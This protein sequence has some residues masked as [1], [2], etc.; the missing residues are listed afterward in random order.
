[1]TSGPRS[2]P[3]SAAT[4]SARSRAVTATRGRR[5]T[6]SAPTSETT[7][8]QRI[9]SC[10]NAVHGTVRSS[11]T[12][13]GARLPAVIRA[14]KRSNTGL[15]LLPPPC[16]WIPRSKRRARRIAQNSST[17]SGGS[18]GGPSGPG[19]PR[20]PATRG[21][22]RTVSTGEGRPSSNAATGG[23]VTSVIAASGYAARSAASAGCATT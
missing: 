3:A 6:G 17:A 22:A 23:E 15:A 21:A 14:P 13:P 20:T 12:A 9:R 18:S 1:M 10:W 16:S 11:G 2:D 8:S 7:S 5:H 4:A 19:S